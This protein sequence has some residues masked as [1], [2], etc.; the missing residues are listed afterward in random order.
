MREV[1]NGRSYIDSTSDAAYMY[2]R[3]N[4]L[5]SS[6]VHAMTQVIASRSYSSPLVNDSK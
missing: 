2:G 1:R 6:P 4:R 5:K 3:D